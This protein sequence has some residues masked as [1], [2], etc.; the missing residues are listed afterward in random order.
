MVFDS[1][2]IFDMCAVARDDFKSAVK[3]ADKKRS[4][5]LEKARKYCSD[6]GY[7]IEKDKADTEYNESVSRARLRTEN[8]FFD[9][10]AVERSKA[11]E[12]VQKIEAGRLAKIK[13]LSDRTMTVDELHAL[14]S[15]DTYSMDY[16]S[17]RVLADIAERS[18]VTLEDMPDI[19]FLPSLST[20]LRVLDEIQSET[21]EMLTG[22]NPKEDSLKDTAYLHDAHITRWMEK[23]TNGLKSVSE[24][25]DS[26]IVKRAISK[27]GG[28]L[29]EA[30]RGK[31]IKEQLEKVPDRCRAALLN[32][33]AS[34]HVI[35]DVAL[36]LSGYESE[37]KSFRDNGGSDE[38][39]KALS[40]VETVK[41][42][43]DVMDEKALQAIHDMR[44]NRYF[45]GELQKS[46][47]DSE[48]ARHYAELA[49]MDKA[50][51]AKTD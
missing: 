45:L 21:E 10:L 15:L 33:I 28:G 32:E 29:S 27:I 48:V 38:Y 22:Y 24:L 30:E 19:H 44:G 25:P 43:S 42:A 39:K 12:Q 51:N 36:K 16:W 47:V 37:I 31:A 26:L 13:L 46:A 8:E 41:G 14:A 7:K 1:V 17:S 35:G 49:E 34:S 5:Q 40:A 2:S 3:K 6:A 50:E 4:R 23:Y 18:N 11:V 9:A 20:K